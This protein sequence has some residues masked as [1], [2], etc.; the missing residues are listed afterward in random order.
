MKKYTVKFYYFT[1]LRLSM[2]VEALNDLMALALVMNEKTIEFW[3]TE[4][5]YRVEIYHNFN[6]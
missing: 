5:G 4:I 3:A 1:D 6:K 2:D